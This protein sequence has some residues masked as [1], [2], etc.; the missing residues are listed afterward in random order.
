[1]FSTGKP[2]IINGPFSI[3]TFSFQKVF[4]L[5]GPD[6]NPR[7]ANPLLQANP[8]ILATLANPAQPSAAIPQGAAA[9][10]PEDSNLIDP[11]VQERL[12]STFYM[13]F[14]FQLMDG[15][16]PI[17][18]IFI[19]ELCDYFHI[20][21]RHARRLNEIMKNRQETFVPDL[22]RLLAGEIYVVGVVKHPTS[23]RA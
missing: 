1:M 18:P 23:M 15:F 6:A 22:E 19:E 5:D 20:E 8:L 16:P 7:F 17:G 2:S 4:F 12:T 14:N 13:G 10:E 9:A 21:E 11:D 3:A